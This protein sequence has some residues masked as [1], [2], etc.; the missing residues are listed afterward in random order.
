MVVGYGLA[1]IRLPW[2]RGRWSRERHATTNGFPAPWDF[3]EST[4]YPK[5]SS[6]SRA[7]VDDNRLAH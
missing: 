2:M 6:S 5:P 4:N 3:G 1:V 7:T